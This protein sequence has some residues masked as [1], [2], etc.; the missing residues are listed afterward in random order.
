MKATHW[1]VQ[2]AI[3]LTMVAFVS[4]PQFRPVRAQ[5]VW[6]YTPSAAQQARTDDAAQ[7]SDAAGAIRRTSVGVGQV[8]Q[9]TF[10]T[11]VPQT[12]TDA[13]RPAG[14]LAAR[15]FFTPEPVAAL[16]G[17]VNALIGMALTSLNAPIPYAKVLLRDIRTG[18]VQARATANEQGQFLF[19]D[20]DASSYIVELLGAAGSVVAASQTVTLARGDVGQTEVR[21]AASATTVTASFGNALTGTLPQATTVASSNDVTR[22]TPTLVAQE[23]SR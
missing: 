12:Q 6:R 14:D 17:K 4:W 23:S 18:Q 5:S 8:G 2:T 16:G 19:I 13:A 20:L 1:A 3:V 15:T 9:A 10:M 11:T 22:T 7:Y 21:A